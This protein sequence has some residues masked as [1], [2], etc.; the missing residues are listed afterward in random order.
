M[1]GRCDMMSGSVN[2]DV[3]C[4]GLVKIITQYKNG[5]EAFTLQS[6]VIGLCYNIA[7]WCTSAYNA[8]DFVLVHLCS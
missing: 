7:R 4:K 6:T 3:I 5:N 8:A 1:L 2:P